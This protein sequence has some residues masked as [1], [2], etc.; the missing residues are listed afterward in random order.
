MK[1]LLVC[2]V[3]AVAGFGLAIAV[4]RWIFKHNVESW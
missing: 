1:L 4:F 2:L 3:G